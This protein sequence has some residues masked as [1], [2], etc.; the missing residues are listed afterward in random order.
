MAEVEEWTSKEK[1]IARLLSW[2]IIVSITIVIVGGI[3][4]MLEFL[5]SFSSPSSPSQ[6]ID[7]FL[8]LSSMPNGWVYQVLVFGVLI[9]GVILGMIGFSLF[10]KRGQR[11][12]LN[13][14]FKINE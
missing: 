8:G 2:G 5:I 3:Y 10:L 1:F 14:L 12:L 11:F 4:T 9:I 6:I 13:L 7:W